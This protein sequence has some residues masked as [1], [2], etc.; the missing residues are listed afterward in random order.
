MSD[1]SIPREAQEWAIS[2]LH[3]AVNPSYYSAERVPSAE[4]L[5]H[6]RDRAI[7]RIERAVVEL[8]ASRAQRQRCAASIDILCRIAL[9]ARKEAK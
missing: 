9:E 4:I 5:A 7:A 2:W 6:R 1:L 8:S 3:E